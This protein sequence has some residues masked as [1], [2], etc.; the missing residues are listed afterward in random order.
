MSSVIIPRSDQW[1]ADDF[2]SGPQTFT[3]QGVSISA[4]T[5]QPV[6]IDIG[7]PGKVYRPCK[8]MSRVLVATWGPD[9]K[10]YT[11]RSFTLYRDPDVKWGGLAVGGI[12]ISH[13]SH[14]EREVTMALTETR[15]S[16]KPFTVKPLKVETAPKPEPT[17]A[18]DPDTWAVMWREK[19]AD[20]AAEA[21]KLAHAWASPQNNGRRDKAKRIAPDL[22]AAV[23]REVMAAIEV[24]E[25][26]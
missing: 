10:A 14:I 5:E 2:I 7:T 9:A 3:I 12:R 17:T 21:P 16:R 26:Q 18:F 24:L 4:G 22:E 8:S 1:N 19:I 20:P 25:T 11:G 13:L 15:A 6:S 23:T